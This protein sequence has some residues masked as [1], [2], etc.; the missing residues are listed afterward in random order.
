MAEESN[1][2]VLVMMMGLARTHKTLCCPKSS[3]TRDSLLYNTV[4]GTM[5]VVGQG[6]VDLPLRYR[7][8]E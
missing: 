5:H 4:I 7:M 3:V 2:I 1:N 6:G 8:F